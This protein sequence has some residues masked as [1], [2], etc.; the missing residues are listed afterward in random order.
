MSES[1]VGNKHVRAGQ[2][3]HEHIASDGERWKC[4][5]P[6]CEIMEVDPPE[7]GGPAVVQRGEERIYFGSGGR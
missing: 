5:S 3:A 1:T 4:T 6:Y 7:R 2:P